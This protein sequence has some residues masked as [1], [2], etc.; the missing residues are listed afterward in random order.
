MANVLVP[1]TKPASRRPG[2]EST[3]L[4]DG[5]TNRGDEFEFV[6][7]VADGGHSGC[8]I[9]GPP[10]DLLE[11]S[12]HIPEAGEKKLAFCADNLSLLRNFNFGPRPGGDNASIANDD[13]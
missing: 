2:A 11:V 7:A 5:V 4:G 10:F 8:E 6:A 3:A 1:S 12:M 13:G 9:D